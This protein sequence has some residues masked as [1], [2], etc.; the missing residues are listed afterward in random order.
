MGAGEKPERR[1]AGDEG[2]TGVQAPEG[3]LLLLLLILLLWLEPMPILLG[4]L[5]AKAATAAGVLGRPVSL[6]LGNMLAELA[7][8]K[9]EGKALFERRQHT[10]NASALKYN[11]HVKSL[12][13]P[14]GLTLLPTV[15]NGSL[16][17]LGIDTSITWQNSG[18]IIRLWYNCKFVM[19]WMFLPL[20]VLSLAVAEPDLNC[21][22]AV[23]SRC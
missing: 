5:L 17:Q 6:S 23:L 3:V 15:A 11:K 14:C 16:A 9:R 10:V 18:L 7:A 8:V 2:L 1:I 20:A 22:L 13:R 4:T 19:V 21:R 12:R